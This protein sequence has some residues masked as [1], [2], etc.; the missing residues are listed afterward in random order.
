MIKTLSYAI[1]I[2]SVFTCNAQESILFK[3]NIS[4]NKKYTTDISTT[5]VTSIV[6]DGSEEVMENLKSSGMTMPIISK[7]TSHSQ[8]EIVTQKRD[9]KGEIPAIVTYG[10]MTSTITTNGEVDVQKNPFEGVQML[11]TYDKESILRIDSIIGDELDP[12]L[13]KVLKDMMESIQQAIDFPEKPL[14]I[15][16]SFY[17]EIPLSIPMEGMNPLTMQINTTYF[18]KRIKGNFAYFDIEQAIT[19]NISEGQYKIAATGSGDGI[20]EYN[21]TEN[22]MTKYTSNLPLEMNFD[23]GDE[24][25]MSMKIK[26]E[27]V[28]VTRIE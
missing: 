13:E 23:M 25:N 12:Q 22:F 11:V 7:G 9:K 26:S 14:K 21:I 8:T 18:L 16:D 27:T 15:G 24:M 3:N 1:L 20:I 19:M 17:Q 6:I 10:A 28:Q 2:F 5:S 4:P